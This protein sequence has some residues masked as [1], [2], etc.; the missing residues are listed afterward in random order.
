MV[1]KEI[2]KKRA[3]IILLTIPAIGL[4]IAT[5]IFLSTGGS[6]TSKLPWVVLMI[7]VLS[8]LSWFINIVFSIYFSSKIGVLFWKW[9]ISTL[10]MIA[11]VSLLHFITIDVFS[12]PTQYI[13]LI[14]IVNITA[15]NTIIFI[16]N[17]LIDT[18]ETKLQL[19]EENNRL[20]ISQLEAQLAQLKNQIN[21]HFLF[22]ALSSLKS[23][24]RRNPQT[25]ESYLMKLSEFLR[26]SIS[27]N[28][29]LVALKDELQLCNDYIDLQKI[30]FQA[31]L[32]YET[33]IDSN[34][35]CY[36]VPFFALQSLLENAIKHNSID[37]AKPLKIRIEVKNDKVLVIN[38]IQLKSSLQSS[39]QTGLHNLNQRLKIYVEEPMIVTK[40]EHFFKVQLK[41]I[42]R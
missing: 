19:E 32:I 13:W 6:P 33:D 3:K 30:R 26:V 40:D 15:V 20:K 42:K 16:I 28:E 4:M 24:M 27:K 14:R 29:D 34:S 23:L 38:N 1:F 5:P 9:L 11:A 8:L 17:M 39:S 18:L 22:N 31:G 41:L 21:P 10:L 2:V 12:L 25:A 35:L 7:S 37:S 36:K